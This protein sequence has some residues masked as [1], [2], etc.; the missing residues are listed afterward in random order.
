MIKSL[1]LTTWQMR[2]LVLPCELSKV[3]T[4]QQLRVIDPRPDPSET[5]FLDL[6]SALQVTPRRDPSP[7]EDPKMRETFSQLFGDIYHSDNSDIHQND[8]H[9]VHQNGTCHN[10]S[11]L[12]EASSSRQPSR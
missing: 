3:L 6:S 11:A 10:I 12:N 4:E 8:D 7:S 9:D 2:N 1:H 5:E